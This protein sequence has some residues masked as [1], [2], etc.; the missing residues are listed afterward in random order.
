LHAFSPALWRA[1]SP[2]IAVPRRDRE[3][4]HRYFF[5]NGCEAAIVTGAL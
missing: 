5:H 4:R 3:K 2:G 1:E